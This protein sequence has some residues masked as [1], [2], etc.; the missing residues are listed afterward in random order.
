M[1]AALPEELTTGQRFSLAVKA[2]FGYEP[3]PPITES[4]EP[5]VRNNREVLTKP[6]QRSAGERWKASWRESDYESRL[7]R[8]IATPRPTLRHDRHRLAEGRGGEDHHD[9]P[10]RVAAGAPAAR[11]HRG[12]RHQPRLRVAGRTLTP[13]HQVFVDDLGDVLEQPDLS[14]TALIAIW[15]APSTA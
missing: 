12:R 1:Q 4:P 9:R 7:D 3:E 15:G 10:A 6:E 2:F 5:A 14:V 13:D 11:P 8:L